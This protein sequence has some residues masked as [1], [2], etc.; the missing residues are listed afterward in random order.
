MP[1]KPSTGYR[2]CGVPDVVRVTNAVLRRLRQEARSTP[3]KECCG[4][5]AGS[6]QTIT[7]IY[8]APNACDAPDAYEI[9]P[10]EL[11]RLMREIHSRR[12]ELLGIYHSHPTGENRPSRRDIERAYYPDAAYF[13]LSPRPDA[14]QSVRAFSIHDGGVSE[15]LIEVV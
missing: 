4:L 15:L 7:V 12:L 6:D 11:F 1:Y 2:L 14:P 3:D 13:I 9:A 5:L 8:P 10:V